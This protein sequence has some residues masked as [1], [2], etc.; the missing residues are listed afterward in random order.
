MDRQTLHQ[1]SPVPDPCW[2]LVSPMKLNVSGKCFMDDLIQQVNMLGFKA[3]TGKEVCRFGAGVSL[4]LR[5]TFAW[6]S[7]ENQLHL[8]IV[9]HIKLLFY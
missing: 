2:T 1:I 7:S 9:V 8:F 5:P 6:T 4:V 3:L